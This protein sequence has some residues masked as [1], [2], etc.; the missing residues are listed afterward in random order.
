MEVV[1]FTLAGVFFVFF[2]LRPKDFGLLAV[3]LCFFCVALLF[4]LSSVPIFVSFVLI[5]LALLV[6]VYTIWKVSASCKNLESVGKELDAANKALKRFV[7]GEFLGFIGNRS[8]ETI[9][10]GSSLEAD[11]AILLL[12]AKMYGSASETMSPSIVFSFFNELLSIVTS[13]VTKNGGFIADYDGDAM[14]VLFP[15]GA[16]S[17]LRSAVQIQSAITGR[18]KT[19]MDKKP[20]SVNIGL[21]IGKVALGALG[22]R[23]RLDSAFLSDCALCALKFDAAFLVFGSKI[24][25]NGLVYSALCEPLGWFIRPIDKTEV[26]D[27]PVFLFEVYNN[28]NDSLRDRK[29]KTQNDLERLVFAFFS[30]DLEEARMRLQILLRVFPEDYV[31]RRYASR[32]H[33]AEINKDSL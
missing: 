22:D 28:D 11:I 8:V 18:N 24:I 10:S 25:I 2:A 26:G 32:L 9:E 23:A 4:F 21:T 27:K 14:T 7:P 30:D 1:F 20:L 12:R 29:W 15:E 17:A 3:S 33:L 19:N 16:D 6:L 31:V 13:V 5:I